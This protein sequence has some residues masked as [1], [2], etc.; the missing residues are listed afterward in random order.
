MNEFEE[1][2]TMAT[3]LFAKSLQRVMESNEFS[4]SVTKRYEE[5]PNIAIEDLQKEIAV[6]AIDGL[7]KEYKIGGE[8]NE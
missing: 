3:L 7:S 4:I 1:K 6:T 2:F 8:N 5:N